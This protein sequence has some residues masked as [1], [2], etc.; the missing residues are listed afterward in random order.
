MVTVADCGAHNACIAD[1]LDRHLCGLLAH[2]LAEAELTV[3][4]QHGAVIADQRCLG[5][6]FQQAGLNVVHVRWNHAHAV[7][8]VTLEV[9]GDQMVSHLARSFVSGARTAENVCGEPLEFFNG[10]LHP[11]VLIAPDSASVPNL[12]QRGSTR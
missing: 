10:Q 4:N 6:V 5:I 7:R 9:G 3:D 8:V 12:R 1:P 2:N 11:G